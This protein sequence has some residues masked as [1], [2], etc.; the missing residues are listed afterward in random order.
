MPEKGTITADSH[1]PSIEDR[2]T[3]AQ[4]AAA[5]ELWELLDTLRR[6]KPCRYAHRQRFVWRDGKTG[7]ENR[8]STSTFPPDPE[9]EWC[10]LDALLAGDPHA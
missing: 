4:Y 7:H 3:P 5:A 10:L 1:L 6:H 2:L 9:C 8:E